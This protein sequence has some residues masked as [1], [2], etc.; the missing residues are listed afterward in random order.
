MTT[1]PETPTTPGF[2]ERF[3]RFVVI[4]MDERVHTDACPFCLDT[5]C[6]C[7]EDIDLLQ[8]YILTPWLTGLL[9]NEEGE[10]LMNGQQ[11]TTLVSMHTT[12]FVAFDGD[13]RLELEES[14]GC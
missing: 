10:R 3:L 6:P 7:Y 9:T 14:R 2:V 4:D 1:T 13:D 8:E 5:S 12:P 11:I